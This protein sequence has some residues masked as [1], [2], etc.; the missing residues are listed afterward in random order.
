MSWL[1]DWLDEH[2]APPKQAG[3][4]GIDI[5]Y[6][7]I[8]AYLS[9]PWLYKLRYKDMR[10][11]PLHPA[12]A[13]GLSIHRTLE[14][15]HRKDGGDY[16][17]LVEQYEANWVSAG[18]PSPQEQM[19]WHA[20]GIEILKTYWESE[21]DSRNKIVAVEREFL[22]PIG[23]HNVRGMID[24]IDRRPDGSIE[25]IDYKSF[26]E[27]LSEEEA[28]EDLQLRIYGLA[29]VASLNLEPDWLS[30]YY[31]GVPKKVT[32]P[33]DADRGDELEEFLGRMGDLLSGGKGW[34][35]DTSYCGR[36]DFKNLCP[37]STA[38]G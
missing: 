12:A 32:V 22:F 19:Q 7:Q 17:A 36:C 20:R 5:S 24:R 18:F 29:A 34:R 13:L 23:A 30:F 28:A 15:F 6:S 35:P 25:V 33:Y 9:C 37:H 2:P 21:K 4:W 3:P 16:T 14:A 1:R 27:T 26:L 31:V 11:S 10:R 8:R 38:R